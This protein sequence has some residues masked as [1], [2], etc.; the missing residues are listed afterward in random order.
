VRE[1]QA[2]DDVRPG[3]DRLDKLVAAVARGERS[4]FDQLFGLLCDPVYAMALSILR[5]QAQA[6]EVAQDVLTEI[7]RTAGRHDPRKASVHVWAMMITRRRAIDRIRSV[8]ASTRQ[9]RQS[10]Y[11]PVSRDLVSEAAEELSD[12][13][14]LGRALDSLTGPQRQVIELAF[15]HGHSHGQIAAMLGIPTGTV[16]SRIRAALAMLRCRMRAE[17]GEQG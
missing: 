12:R 11:S 4:A 5:D 1:H 15:Y 6:E 8:T 10:A 7:W 2:P 3:T 13:E 16:K 17:A 9:E 14:Q